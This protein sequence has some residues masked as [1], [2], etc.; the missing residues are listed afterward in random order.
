MK[1]SVHVES[2][3]AWRSNTLRGFIDI[4]IPEMHLRIIDA[5]VHES[6]GKRW[7]G[8]PAMLT[9]DG[10][11]RLDERGKT[12]YAPVLQFTDR[13]TSDAFSQRVI[14]ACSKIFPTLSTTRR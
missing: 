11:V 5:T 8:L 3:K 14:A 7:I 1:L 12:A 6:H 2:F 4:I 9:R 13:A 10:G